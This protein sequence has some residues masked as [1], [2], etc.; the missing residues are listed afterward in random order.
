[1]SAHRPIQSQA[2]S[3]LLEGLLGLLIFSTGVLALVA[4][5]AMSVRD[6]AEA[7]YRADA[8]FLAN[9]IIGRMWS[10]RA[11]LASYRHNAGLGVCSS[12]V[13]VSGTQPVTDWLGSVA[14]SLPGATGERQQI[15]VDA[16]NLV[17]VTICWQVT[18]TAPH[19][20]VVATQIQG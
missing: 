13:G 10:D 5:Q 6:T 15:N 20:L 7:K 17:T 16:N 3:V 14:A 19:N 1:M 18:D 9:Q 12:G 8:S 2:G 4:L 11:S